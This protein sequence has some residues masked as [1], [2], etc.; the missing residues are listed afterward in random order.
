MLFQGDN[1]LEFDKISKI[2]FSP[3]GTTLKIVNEIAK[4]FELDNENYDLLSFDSEKEFEN[5]LVIVGVPSFD[6]RIPKLA[7]E[8]LSKIKGHNTK[9]IAILNYGNIDYGDSLLEL[10]DLLKKNGFDLIGVCT[11]V[12]QHS[13][14]GEIAKGRP[15]EN[16]LDKISKFAQHIKFKLE[17]NIENEL[18]FAG[19]KPYKEY[20]KPEFSVNCDEDLCVYC[21]D[22]VYTCPEEAIMEDEPTYT[23][24]DRCSRC[25]TCINVCG[26]D[27]RSFAG[28][29][30]ENQYLNALNEF[31]D[32]KEG[33][34]FF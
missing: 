13:Q 7:C 9:A 22:C 28:S 34:F 20:V 33:E 30:Y 15:D 5:E 17:N 32:R 19:Q 12:S 8:R 31:N 6:G 27:A 4:N 2:F 3:S 11:T 14:F 18:F 29:E 16:D 26:Q 1:M 25:S 23:D 10:T 24:L 21:N